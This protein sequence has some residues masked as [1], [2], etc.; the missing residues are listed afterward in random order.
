MEIKYDYGNSKNKLQKQ[1]EEMLESANR[2]TYKVYADL[3]SSNIHKISKG[4]KE[5]KLENFYDNMNEISVPLDQKLSAVQN[6]QKYYK[7][8]QKMKQ[9]ELRYGPCYLQR[10]S[11]YKR[12]LK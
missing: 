2:E 10:S 8:Y 12:R 11:E 4:L 5:I 1:K 6:A 3:I 7:R 9:R